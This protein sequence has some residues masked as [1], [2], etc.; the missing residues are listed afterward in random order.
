MKMSHE[1]SDFSKKKVIM[2]NE[3]HSGEWKTLK[4]LISHHCIQQEWESGL[5][6]GQKES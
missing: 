2:N 3:T 5:E 4:I 1:N 6:F